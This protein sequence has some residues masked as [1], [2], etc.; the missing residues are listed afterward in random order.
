MKRILT[1]ALLLSIPLMLLFVVVQ[2]ADH[3][4]L[5]A[6]L[7]VLEKEQAEMVEQNRQ[8]LSG[9]AAAAA[10]ARIEDLIQRDGSFVPISPANTLRILVQPQKGRQDG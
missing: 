1:F 4:E 2:S 10:R 7:R 9:L 5:V 8:L 6:E 3:H